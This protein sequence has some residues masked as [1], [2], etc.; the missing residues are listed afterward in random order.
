MKMNRYQTKEKRTTHLDEI[1]PVKPWQPPFE[2]ALNTKPTTIPKFRIVQ[3]Q[4]NWLAKQFTPELNCTQMINKK[5]SRRT[6]I[7]ITELSI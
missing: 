2:W 3:G 7:T 5:D 4:K 1:E 6:T